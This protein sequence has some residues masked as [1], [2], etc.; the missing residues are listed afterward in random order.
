MSIA[1]DTDR[2]SFLRENQANLRLPGL[3]DHDS[4]YKYI[5]LDGKQS[6]NY[7]AQTIKQFQVIGATASSLNDPLEAKPRIIDDID[8]ENFAD[9]CSYFNKSNM[10]EDARNFKDVGDLSQ[11][12]TKVK[13]AVEK[14]VERARILSFCRRSDSP[15][16]WSHYARSHKGACIHF[17][18]NAFPNKDVVKGAV[19]YQRNRPVV[20][21]SLPARISLAGKARQHPEDR[22]ALRVELFNL[23]FF[24]K[25]EDWSYE[26]EVRLIY[27]SD[28]MTNLEFKPSGMFEIIVGAR[29]APEDEDRIR[30]L[31]NSSQTHIR[32]RKAVIDTDTFSVG[33]A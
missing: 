28:T 6:W 29:C 23:C 18:A 3:S 12:S 15:L 7:L 27:M 21:L 1:V 17:S 14:L 31:A 30:N 25:P 33:I 22:A 8:D 5:S 10:K 26:E 2:M 16:L 20:P 11:Y 13:G 4:L 24:V 19:R 32:V 9:I